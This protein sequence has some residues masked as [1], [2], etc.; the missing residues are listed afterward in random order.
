LVGASG[1][2]AGAT[3]VF[4]SVQVVD[5]AGVSTGV[6][7]GYSTGVSIGVGWTTT[8]VELATGTTGTSNTY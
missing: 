5:S 7:T 1:V 8:S 4:D 2:G 6:W 3:G